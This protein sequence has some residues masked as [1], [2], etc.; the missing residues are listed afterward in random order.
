MLV[1]TA[2]VGSGWYPEDD[3]EMGFPRGPEAPGACLPGVEGGEDAGDP[4]LE[5][6]GGVGRRD[7]GGL[8]AGA[9]DAG[10]VEAVE[11]GGGPGG[12]STPWEEQE[13]T[14][15]IPPPVECGAWLLGL[16]IAVAISGEAAACARGTCM[17]SGEP[18]P[19]ACSLCPA[20]AGIVAYHAETDAWW[21]FYPGGTECR[22]TPAGVTRVHYGG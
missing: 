11:T 21:C 16:F 17:C 18:E 5:E 19:A 8:G 15:A 14:L 7:G 3:G 10:S 20:E 4:G 2:C 9:Y 13:P 22:L 1:G 6:D 12:A